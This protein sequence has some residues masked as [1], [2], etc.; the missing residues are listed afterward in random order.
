MKQSRGLMAPNVQKAIQEASVNIPGKVETIYQPLYDYQTLAATA[1]AQ[2][3]FFQTPVGQG[4]KTL[5]DTNMELAGQ[6]PKGQ[7]FLITGI[8][9]EVL[10]GL[11]VSQATLNEFANDVYEVTKGGV[12]VLRI[13]SKEYVRQG[14]LMKFPPVNRLG[15]DAATGLTAESTT[16]A[17]ACGR[18][19]S[20]V[21]LL[22]TSN[23]N[24]S[25]ELRDLPALP[26]AVAGRIGITLNGYL[27]RN[28]Q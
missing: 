4:G 15:V 14:N 28:A 10:P 9:V 17:A 26:S 18:E 11:D 27:M 5:A 22:L 1:V 25:V 19:F 21:D 13:G 20:V 7:N 6:L 23:Q 2:Q 3:T 16:Y 24:F 8:Q 12:L